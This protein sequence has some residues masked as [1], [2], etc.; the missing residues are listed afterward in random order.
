MDLLATADQQGAGYVQGD[1]RERHG[2][3]MSIKQYVLS[4]VTH[5]GVVQMLPFVN[6][7]NRTS[8]KRTASGEDRHEP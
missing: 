5:F 4:Q 8:L 1:M 7:T 2:K 3:K 6:V